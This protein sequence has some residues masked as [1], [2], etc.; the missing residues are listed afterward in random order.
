MSYKLPNKKSTKLVEIPDDKLQTKI[1][2]NNSSL[3]SF[4]KLLLATRNGS[5]NSDV[6]PLLLKQMLNEY[7][8]TI[9]EAIEAFKKAYS[10]HYTPKSGIEWRHLYKHIEEMRKGRDRQYYS[11]RE[12]LNICDRED[13]TT[14]HFTRV[15]SEVSRQKQENPNTDI[16]DMLCWKRK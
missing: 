12:V 10:D 7:E 14:D 11:Y 1:A 8:V 5:W 15:E 16:K 3:K 4:S 13:I 9:G 2:Q 6:E